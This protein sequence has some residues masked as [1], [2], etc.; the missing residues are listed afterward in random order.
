MTREE[1]IYKKAEGDCIAMIESIERGDIIKGSICPQSY[2]AGFMDGAKWADQYPQWILVE[3]ELPKEKQK[4]LA[5]FSPNEECEHEYACMALYNY[6]FH[7]WEDAEDS[8]II[9]EGITHWM[10]MPQPPK[11]DEQY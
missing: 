4:V 6:G 3:Q 9:L 7:H 8:G 2:R 5:Y 11:K 10:P 1:Q